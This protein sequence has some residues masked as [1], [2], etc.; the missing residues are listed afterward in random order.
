MALSS[1][2]Q[3]T[4]DEIER[5]LHDDDPTF[6]EANLDHLR[7][8]QWVV[9]AFAFTLG[10]VA[11]VAGEIMSLAF[12]AAGMIMGVAGFFLMFSAFAWTSRDHAL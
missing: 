1:E 12:V 4:L 10:L 3:R 8:R 11:L 5:A 9:R 7:H 2:E 6:M